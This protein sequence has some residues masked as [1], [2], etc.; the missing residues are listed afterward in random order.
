MWNLSG[1]IGTFYCMYEVIICIYELTV[2]I[3]IV[4]RR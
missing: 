2:N 1:K 4:E 3:Y